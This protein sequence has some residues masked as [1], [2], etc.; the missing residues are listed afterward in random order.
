VLT[1]GAGAKA[2]KLDTLLQQVYLIRD[3]LYGQVMAARDKAAKGEDIVEKQLSQVVADDE[4]LTE[5]EAV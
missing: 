4:W 3:E 1:L 5:G 2:N